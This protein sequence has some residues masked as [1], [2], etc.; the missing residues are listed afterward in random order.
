VIDANDISGCG[1]NTEVDAGEV[2]FMIRNFGDVDG[3]EKIGI[4]DV[5]LLRSYLTEASGTVEIKAGADANGDGT[6]DSLD[7]LHIRRYLANYNYST[8]ESTVVLGP[9]TN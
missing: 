7:L 5:V 9:N 4:L 1:V 6:I 8:G 2:T 3:D